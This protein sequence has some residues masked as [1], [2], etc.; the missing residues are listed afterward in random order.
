MELNTYHSINEL[1]A[2]LGLPSDDKS[3]D[4][5]IEHHKPLSEKINIVDAPW[6]NEV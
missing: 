3:I 5:F 2:Q 4:E 6:W 1:F